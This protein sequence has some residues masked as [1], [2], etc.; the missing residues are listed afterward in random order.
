MD[1]LRNWELYAMTLWYQY[2][3]N[4]VR[5]IPWCATDAGIRYKG[6]T[7]AR[8]AVIAPKPTVH[9]VPSISSQ[10]IPS[11]LQVKNVRYD[12]E[13]FSEPLEVVRTHHTIV[14]HRFEPAGVST[15]STR[16]RAERYLLIRHGVALYLPL[17]VPFFMWGLSPSKTQ[18][19]SSI[20]KPMSR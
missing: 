2:H 6:R 19:W 8:S 16:T 9:I 1:S 17:F 7:V 13:R 11:T 12:F 18:F 10:Y 5:Y 15:P 20:D 14:K 4:L 3:M